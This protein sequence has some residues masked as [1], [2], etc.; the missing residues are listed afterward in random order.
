MSK[1]ANVEEMFKPLLAHPR[2]NLG[3][4]EHTSFIDS[5]YNLVRGLRRPDYVRVLVDRPD[6]R[7]YGHPCEESGLMDIY[8]YI[9]NSDFQYML[10][11]EHHMHAV[12][13]LPSMILFLEKTFSDQLDDPDLTTV[14][15]P[16]VYYAYA[17]FY[18]PGSD[19]PKHSSDLSD[20]EMDENGDADTDWPTKEAVA[21]LATRGYIPS[22]MAPNGPSNPILYG[23]GFW[24]DPGEP[25]RTGLRARMQIDG[26]SFTTVDS[27]GRGFI[28]VACL[29][30]DD[31]ISAIVFLLGI[32]IDPNLRDNAGMQSPLS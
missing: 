26:I 14:L 18:R 20:T 3:K 7:I 9:L 25:Q 11:G 6:F 31:W 2:F 1:E 24:D 10:F 23:I 28:H 15:F 27:R 13:N 17:G 5:L 29:K 30:P 16:F 21:A 22:T 8:S 12:E 19:Q 32:G 4:M